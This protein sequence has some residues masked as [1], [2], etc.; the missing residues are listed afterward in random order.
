MSSYRHVDEIDRAVHVARKALSLNHLRRPDR[1][2]R[3]LY[4]R[5]YLGQ[6][7]HQAEIPAQRTHLWQ[8][9]STRRCTRSVS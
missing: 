6:A 5:W 3:F 8:A 2:T 4:Q 9:W 7:T 1:L